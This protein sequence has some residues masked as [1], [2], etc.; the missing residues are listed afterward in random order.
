MAPVMVTCTKSPI[1]PTLRAPQSPQ[2]WA[3]W[4]RPV[5]SPHANGV[6]RCGLRVSLSGSNPLGANPTRSSRYQPTGNILLARALT[7]ISCRALINVELQPP[8]NLHFTNDHRLSYELDHPSSWFVH[9]FAL[10]LVT[11]SGDCVCVCAHRCHQAEAP[12]A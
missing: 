7:D 6:D 9:L 2:G 3:S 8:T 10:L 11:K 4:G 12:P 5:A 1:C